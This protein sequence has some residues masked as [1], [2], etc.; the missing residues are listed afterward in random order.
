MDYNDND[1]SPL[2]Y[3]TGSTASFSSTASSSSSSPSS[4]RKK[5]S[6]IKK[7][8]NDNKKVSFSSH[9]CNYSLI[10]SLIKP[11]V[12]IDLLIF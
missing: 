1:D 5:Y 12:M 7:D 2:K 4:W 9:C 8:E 3:A 11:Y 10:I 6:F